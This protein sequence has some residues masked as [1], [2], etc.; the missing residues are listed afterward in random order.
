M[1]YNHSVENFNEACGFTEEQAVATIDKAN[2]IAKS[3]LDEDDGKLSK[4][5]EKYESEDGLTKRELA[6]LVGKLQQ[7]LAHFK[8]MAL[9]GAKEASVEE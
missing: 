4:I 1:S 5:V 6:W 7:D 9:M 2:N 3:I 8:F